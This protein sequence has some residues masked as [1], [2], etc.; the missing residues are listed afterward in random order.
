[1]Y[2]KYS[3]R[4][5]MS[6]MDGELVHDLRI[7]LQLISGCAQLLEQ[8]LGQNARARGYVETLLGSVGQMQRMLSGAME[9]RRPEAG[10]VRWTRSDVVSRT[11]EV[12]SRCRLYAAPRGAAPSDDA[13]GSRRRAARAESAPRGPWP[14]GTAAPAAA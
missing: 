5:E 9:R 12:F 8:E 7:P 2:S 1:M 4:V 6:R 10:A 11:W 13:P 3:E 14:S